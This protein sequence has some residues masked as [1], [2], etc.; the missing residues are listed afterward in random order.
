MS[1]AMVLSSSRRRFVQGVFL[2]GVAA[3]SGLLRARERVLAAPGELLAGHDFRLDIGESL[4]TSPDAR[5][6]RSP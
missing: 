6:R 5:A 1:E 2:G 4:S 3:S